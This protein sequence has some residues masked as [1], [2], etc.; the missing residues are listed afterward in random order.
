MADDTNNITTGR[1]RIF[2]RAVRTKSNKYIWS[3]LAILLIGLLVLIL[4]VTLA[5][6]IL[7]IALGILL[8]IIGIVRMLI[9][10]IAP[11]TPLDTAEIEVEE[12]EKEIAL[13]HPLVEID[14][15]EE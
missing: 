14:P 9:G 8:M 12:P 10:I 1:L 15:S 3:G 5:A 11:A 7:V 13:E 2:D 6:N 4:T